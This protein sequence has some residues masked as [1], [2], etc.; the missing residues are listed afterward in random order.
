[1][2]KKFEL[3][4]YRE[5]LKEEI[6]GLT[7]TA[8]SDEDFAEIDRKL[9]EY[10]KIKKQIEAL[11]KAEDVSKERLVKAATPVDTSVEDP[12][13]EAKKVAKA[14]RFTKAFGDIKNSGKLE[15]AEA[16]MFQEAQREA[17]Q[18]GVSLEGNIAI[19]SYLVK[20]A[21]KNVQKRDLTVA[22]EGG[23]IVPVDFG[24]LIPFL[25]PDPVV[26][27]A[28]ATMRTGLSGDYQRPRSTNR[29]ALVW[30]GEN[31]QNAETT[32]TYDNVKWT[33][34]RLSGFVDIS[35]QAMIQSS[36]SVEQDVR[37]QLNRELAL[38]IDR[39]SISG[40]SGGDNP[41]GILNTSGIGAVALGTNGGPITW[42]AVVDLITQVAQDDALM[43]SLGF[44]TTHGVKG[45]LMQTPKQASGVE[46][47]FIQS[48]YDYRVNELAGFPLYASNQ[49]PSNLTKGTSSGVCHA[50]IFGNFSEWVIAQWGGVDILMDP[51]T[52]AGLG[53]MRVQVNAYMDAKAYHPQSFAA[54]QDITIS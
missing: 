2:K 21:G 40:A 5:E 19:P 28:G 29:T 9:E 6:E 24:D 47:Q 39:A 8:E 17:K 18:S 44:I 20:Y 36:F 54:I 30:E 42:A 31:D 27:R 26:L 52:Q 53:L 43:G 49:A 37:S 12:L 41:V 11:E 1:M 46:G 4:E 7:E 45:E 33:P 3:I 34:K 14:F 25:E 10:S 35:K 22:T 48:A 38:A 50:M 51:Y 13:K 15:G 23:D 32:P 16:E